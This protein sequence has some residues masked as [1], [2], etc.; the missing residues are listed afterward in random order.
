M[1]NSN[2]KTLKD[3]VSKTLNKYQ[4]RKVIGGNVVTNVG[5]I[6]NKGV[7]IETSGS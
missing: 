4:G 1:K 2:Q 5:E 7:E 6:E 3:F